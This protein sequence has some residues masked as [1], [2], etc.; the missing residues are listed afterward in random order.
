M[1]IALKN[2]TKLLQA[3]QKIVAKTE[4]N[5]VQNVNREKVVMSWQIGQLVDEYLLEN[6]QEQYRKKLL[7]ELEKDTAITTRALYQ[8][9]SFYKAYPTLP[10][11]E[12]DLSWSHYR[13]LSSVANVET[14]KRLEDLTVSDGLGA[15]KLQSEI[16]KIKSKAKKRREKNVS[17]KIT[18]LSVKR[19]QLFTYKIVVSPHTNK[20][21]IDCGFNIF[22]EIKTSLK[23]DGAVVK[24][25]KKGTAFSLKKSAA[26]PQQ[27]HTYKAYLDKV[28]D[29]DT[30][31]VT[32]DLG[33]K[34]EHKEILRLAK[35][36]APEAKEIAGKKSTAALQEILK[37]AKFLIVKTNKTDIY[38]RYVADVFF[39][40]SGKETNPQKVADSGIYLNQLLLDRGLVEAF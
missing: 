20:T 24:S 25:V 23:A 35:I 19:G 37:D 27:L 11:Q 36:N 10:A 8:M 3:I 15:D 9:R 26:K 32:L 22:T 4:Q 18:K 1:E 5:I 14:R 16:S 17:K 31:H 33:F 30:L 38:G 13:S 28:V 29:G 39:D 7:E 6:D 34:I 40:E 21:L 12:S 2:Y